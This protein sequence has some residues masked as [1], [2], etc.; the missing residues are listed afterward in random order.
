MR[1]RSG[2][3]TCLSAC[4]HAWRVWSNREVRRTLRPLCQQ[5][6]PVAF[7]PPP[8]GL[9]TSAD[10]PG[11]HVDVCEAKPDAAGRARGAASVPLFAGRAGDLPRVGGC[12]LWYRATCHSPVGRCSHRVCVRRPRR[13]A[14]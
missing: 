8:V 3:P 1:A 7:L 11:I 2:L 9:Q 12:L 4:P 6:G 13:V 14:S 10:S 5:D